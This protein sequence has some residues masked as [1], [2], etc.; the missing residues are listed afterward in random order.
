MV[1]FFNFI[2]Y[3]VIAIWDTVNVDIGKFNGVSI[4]LGD[5]IIVLLI[6]AIVINAVVRSVKA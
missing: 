4:R 2:Y 5:C 3:A 1:Q 6:M